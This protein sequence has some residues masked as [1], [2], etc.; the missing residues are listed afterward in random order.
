M[1]NTKRRVYV[2]ATY[3]TK[4]HEAADTWPAC[5]RATVWTW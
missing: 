1:T 2:A 5:W 4:G 3:D